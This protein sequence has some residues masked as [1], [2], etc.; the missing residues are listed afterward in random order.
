MVNRVK[1]KIREDKIITILLLNKIPPGSSAKN[2][3]IPDRIKQTAVLN[4]IGARPAMVVLRAYISKIQPASD[5]TP[6]RNTNMPAILAVCAF[7]KRM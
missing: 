4:F 1:R 5:I 3:A 7:K 2:K 6:E